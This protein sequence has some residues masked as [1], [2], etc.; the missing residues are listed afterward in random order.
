MEQ[1]K[2][3]T[4]VAAARNGSDEAYRALLEAY[5]SGLVGYFYRNTGSRNEADDLVQETFLHLV[6]GLRN[7][8]E[9]ERFE[10]WL[11][12]LARNLLV[13]YWRKHKMVH[14]VDVGKDDSEEWM[15][16]L[17]A[18]RDIR[19]PSDMLMEKEMGDE[20]Q[21]ALMKLSSD[22]RETILMRYFSE[23]SFEEIAEMSG[24]PLGTAL[25][26]VHRGLKT[27]KRL[28]GN[29]VEAGIAEEGQRS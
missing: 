5:G 6:R 4:I 15:P 22:Q 8:K 7:Y 3:S 1:T 9:E 12:R 27:L 25:A 28:M 26:R 10:V 20:L 11:Y 18:N 14:A 17:P 2:I 16:E 24:V 19:E 21:K 13:D 23:L 29:E